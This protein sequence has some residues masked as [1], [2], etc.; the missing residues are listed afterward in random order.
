MFKKKYIRIVKW[1]GYPLFALLCFLFSLLLTFPFENIK[2][3]IESTLSEEYNLQVK[4][5][6]LSASLPLGIK[7][8]NLTLNSPKPEFKAFMPLTIPKLRLNVSI[9]STLLGNPG[10]SFAARMFGGE[11]DGSVK[12]G[13]ADTAHHIRMRI[14][15]FQLEEMPSFKQSFKELP[16]KGS[17]SIDTDL[18]FNPQKVKESKGYLTMNIEDGIVGP[19]KMTFQLPKVIT[20]TLNSRFIVKEGVLEVERFEQSSPDMMSDMVGNITLAKNMMYS[21]V[22]L[23]Y[24]FKIS[25]DMLKKHDIFKLALSAIKNA[26]G[27][28]KYYYHTFRGALANMRPVAN[29]AAEYKFKKKSSAKP[30][31]KSGRKSPKAK[32]KGKKKPPAKRKPPKRKKSDIKKQEAEKQKTETKSSPKA[33]PKKRRRRR[34]ASDTSKRSTGRKKK[35][36]IE[37]PVEETEEQV[38]EETAE[39]EPQVTQTGYVIGLAIHENPAES[40]FWGVVETGAKDAAAAMGVE[41]KSGGSNDPADQAQLIET[42]IADGVNGIIVSLA[43]PDAMKDAVMKATDAGIP[44]I[45]INSGVDVYKELGAITHVGQTEFVAGQGAGEQFD[46]AGAAKVLCVIHEEGNIGL[47]ER[48][49]GLADSFSGD[50]ERFNVATTGVRDIAGT[51]ASIQDKLIAD[52]D[53][54]AILTLNPNI[55]DAAMQAI[56]AVGGSQ[57]LAT[58]DLSPDVLE[59]IEAGKMMFA[60]DQQ[61]YLQGYLPVVF[62]Y[63]YNANANTVGGGLPVLTG[64][65]IVDASNA[66]AVKDLAAAGTR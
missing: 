63:L 39:E 46:A 55:A 36:E 43:N 48:C 6:S 27:S 11:I 50:V 56:E 38:A 54:D 3:K 58:F 24:R 4:M 62:L 35:A 22:N 32:S 18:E 8:T 19:G 13:D 7:A 26:E 60:I 21:R 20:G 15:D 28:D 44:V 17:L 14:D 37:E 52:A 42:Y 49:D 51:L 30:A 66:G 33:K 47:E 9:L 1:I 57:K 41:L 64:P 45:T 29:K 40:S 23:D 61:Q 53:I 65:G 2:G 12:V 5:D 10:I 31:K 34:P 25:D 59:A 16:V